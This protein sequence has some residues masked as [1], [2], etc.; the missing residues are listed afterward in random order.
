MGVQPT[1][2]AEKLGEYSF[3]FRFREH[4]KIEKRLSRFYTLNERLAWA[5]SRSFLS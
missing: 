3:R 5:H 1:S 4:H 2:A